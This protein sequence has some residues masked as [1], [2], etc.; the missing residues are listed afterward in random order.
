MRL[1]PLFALQLAPVR[2]VLLSVTMSALINSEQTIRIEWFADA[3]YGKTCFFRRGTCRLQPHAGKQK[4]AL[5]PRPASAPSEPAYACRLK[6]HYTLSDPPKDW[7][8]SSG[9]I[10]LE[11]CQANLFEHQAGTITLLCGPP[12]MLK[13][14]CYPALEQMGYEKGFNAIEF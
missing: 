4:S 9:F 12:P 6:V 3:L 13:F 11:M 14:A 7:A 1:L 5:L 10:N 8:Y 2:M